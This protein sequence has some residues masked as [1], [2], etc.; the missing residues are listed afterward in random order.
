MRRLVSLARKCL[1]MRWRSQINRTASTC[2][3]RSRRSWGHTTRTGLISLATLS[4]QD[5][6]SRKASISAWPL[7]YHCTRH[8]RCSLGTFFILREVSNHGDD[9]IVGFQQH[10]RYL[11]QGAIS[12][13]DRS[14]CHRTKHA[15]YPRP[16]EVHH[17]SDS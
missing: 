7:Q 17:I 14:S 11:E 5:S 12:A 8:L 9:E 10:T 3:I 1:S 4:I 16:D 13:Q 2:G 6:A 15:R